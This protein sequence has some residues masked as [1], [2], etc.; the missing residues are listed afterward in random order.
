MN[1][2][3]TRLT[4]A[5]LGL[6]VVPLLIVG[7]ILIGQTYQAQTQGA[8]LLQRE[9]AARLSSQVQSFFQGQ[10]SQ[11]R[12]LIQIGD[13]LH[14]QPD[15]Q[16]LIVSI[17]HSRQSGIDR[18]ILLDAGGRTLV[19][20]SRVNLHQ[21][22]SFPSRKDL[23]LLLFPLS[24]GETLY[25]PI[26]IDALSGE[27]LMIMAVPIVVLETGKLEG[28]LVADVRLKAVWDL[29]ASIRP[30]KKGESF[31]VDPE[32]RIIAHSNPS[33]VL[34]ETRFD[35]SI[36][37]G[38]QLGQSGEKAVLVSQG[39]AVGIQH[40]R[41]F[42]ESPVSEALALTMQTVRVMLIIVAVVLLLSGGLG[43]L[44][45]RQIIR[46][47]EN[48]AAAARAINAGDLSCRV[49][50]KSRDELG[51]LASA[52]NGMTAQLEAL[53]RDLE[54]RVAERTAKLAA[55]NHELEAFSYTVSHDLRAP[56]RHI[57]GYVDLLTSS[58]RTDLGERGLRY[59]G[60]IA[61]SAR[62]MRELIDDLL[63][64]SRVGR[65]K[66]RQEAVEMNLVLQEALAIAQEACVGR[67]VEWSIGKMPMV[68][69]DSVL[70]R[71][72]WVNLLENAVKFTQSK[73]FARIEVG[74]S[75]QEEGIVFFVA[76]NG[77]G[78]DMEYAD[79]LFEV[80]QRLHPDAEFEGTG[81][82]LAIVRRII[83]RHGGRAWAEGELDRGAKFSF[84][85]P[86]PKVDT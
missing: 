31:I 25:S 8:F 1:S 12:M 50:I 76:D 67:A 6:A 60:N 61:F 82:G 2:I 57:N 49:I 53:I 36:G 85:L 38:I 23:E 65:V 66:M 80:F 58:C 62:Q 14:Q 81:I 75:E 51:V 13:L 86:M 54:N 5:F 10:E 3:R 34:R 19:D 26:R 72:V 56:L 63:S 59:L 16:E 43:T 73:E 9:T 68:R 41:V 32:N 39:I 33:V 47:I 21:D 35:Q 11:L 69:G 48:I 46:P 7:L 55:A 64:F 78:F 79:K 28:M 30:G 24:S 84:L 15:R 17:F 44:M 40:F 74:C 45:V 83:E 20:H 29:V 18:L 70:L 4:L 71:Q 77:A 52:F 22:S 37:D 42:V 27:P